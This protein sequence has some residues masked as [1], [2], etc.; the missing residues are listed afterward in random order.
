MSMECEV[1]GREST[2]LIGVMTCKLC[3]TGGGAHGHNSNCKCV[4]CRL[5]M[6]MRRIVEL[7][8]ENTALR[9]RIANIG[10]RM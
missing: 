3:R 8:T 10:G 1:C 5:G 4:A 9:D 7:K 6:A 2:Q